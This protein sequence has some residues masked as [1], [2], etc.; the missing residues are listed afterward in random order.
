MPWGAA[1]AIAAARSG[2]LGTP[3]IRSSQ[4]DG[5]ADLGQVGTDFE[6]ALLAR[7][8][9]GIGDRDERVET[10]PTARQEQLSGVAA[11]APGVAVVGGGE[12]DPEV[13]AV[14]VGEGSGELF[15]GEAELA[16]LLAHRAG[17]V[18]DD[19]DVDSVRRKLGDEHRW[20][21]LGFVGVVL[22]PGGLAF[23]VTGLADCAAVGLRR[24]VVD[25]T[26]G[27][28][29]GAGDGRNRCQT[30]RGLRCSQENLPGNGRG[31]RRRDRLV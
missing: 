11:L 10:L 29:T 14:G 20:R 19:E 1:Q 16:L 23:G 22:G 17:V 25:K 26:L 7:V 9:G 4:G 21:Q 2:A 13:E 31:T 3:S 27:T 12:C 30:A 24:L 28:A 18:D 6:A 15:E 8:E 5:R